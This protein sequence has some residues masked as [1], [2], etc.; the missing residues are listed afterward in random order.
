MKKML[1]S[2][3]CPLLA[4]LL[5]LVFFNREL[6]GIQL[7]APPAT[8]S[9]ASCA[10]VRYIRH[11]A[12]HPEGLRTLLVQPTDSPT[13]YLFGSSELTSHT[14]YVAYQF[15]SDH[16]PVKVMAS[17]HEGNQC[18]SIFSQLLSRWN[19]LR[20]APIVV[21]LSPG[22]FEAK[23]SR[24]TTSS[25]YLEYLSDAEVVAMQ[26]SQ[27][28]PEFLAYAN[29]GIAGFYA[30]LNA[31]SAGFRYANLRHRA[32][33]SWYHRLWCAPLQAWN[34]ALQWF[35]TP[36][37]KNISSYRF[38]PVRIHCALNMDSIEQLTRGQT[39]RAASNND[40]GI[41]NEY[42]QQYVGTKRGNIYPVTEENNRE[43]ADCRMLIRLLK[44]AGAKASF[45]ISPLNPCYF[46]NLRDL[47]PAM[48]AVENEIAAAG[49]PLLNLYTADST[50]YDKALLGDI[51]H[52]SSY[53]WMQVNK[54]ILQH[55]QLCQ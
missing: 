14:P 15:I 41:E 51:M 55:Y 46:K 48:R 43:L 11:F 23:P 25:V 39:L 18:F 28:A 19:Y 16:F 26:G 34:G 47:D 2:V 21:I 32:G 40:L 36:I 22:W 9:D 45:V 49:F 53:G 7:P 5:L 10:S 17:G 29:K 4:A 3:V 52:M 37:R 24:G 1:A 13:I 50:A 20:G 6:R 8:V 54:F 12:D 42:Y 27:L 33:R 35:G 31:P 44:S 38:Q 30:E